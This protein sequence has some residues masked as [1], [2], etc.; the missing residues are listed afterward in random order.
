MASYNTTSFQFVLIDPSTNL[1]YWQ[2]TLKNGSLVIAPF[3]MYN[4][5]SP[6]IPIPDFN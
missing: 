3:G 2:V 6:T 4:Y 5:S 1:K